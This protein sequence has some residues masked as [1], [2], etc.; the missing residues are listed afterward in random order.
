[1]RFVAEAGKFGFQFQKS[2][3]EFWLS[4]WKK[5]AKFSEEYLCIWENS[6][7]V[8]YKGDA[9]LL[10]QGQRTLSWEIEARSRDEQS[11]ILRENFHIGNRRLGTQHIRRVTKAS[12]GATFIRGYGLVKLDQDQ[13]ED[14]EWW[15]RNRGDAKR[16]N[17]PRYMLFSLLPENIYA[18]GRTDIWNFGEIRSK[19]WKPM[20]LERNFHFFALSDAR[21]CSHLHALHQLGCHPLLADEMGLGKTV[22]TLALVSSN[23]S[24]ELPDLVTCPASVVPVWVKE[25]AKHFPKV[26]VRVLCK[27]ETFENAEDACL[28]IASYTQLRRHRHLLDKVNFRY[29]VLD[30]ATAH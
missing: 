12:Q 29:A 14:F 28:W 5:V 9:H 3:G 26:K 20:E 7:E 19:I 2:A 15:Q 1:M 23:P 24:P 4:D 30:E 8:E 17:W 27:D 25:A 21:S 11:M 18:H 13:V 6:F 22:Q 16:A 10:K